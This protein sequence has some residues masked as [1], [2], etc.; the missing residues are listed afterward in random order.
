MQEEFVPGQRWLSEAE[1]DLG[2]GVVEEVGARQVKLNFAASGESRNYAAVNAPLSRVLFVPD[3]RVQDEDGQNLVILEVENIAGLLFYRCVNSAGVESVLPEQSLND[4]LRL[5]RPQ[6]KLLARRIDADIWFTLRYQSWLQSAAQW[7]SPVFG[8][9][10]PRIDLIP[11]QLYIAS[12]VASRAS[13][14]V[15]LA[16]EVGLG[17]TIEAGLVLHRLVL[18]ERVQ[19]VLVILPDAL[20]HQWLVEML[21]RFNMQF[22]VF[23]QDRFDNVDHVN[24]FQAEQRV[25]CSL[26]F[27]TASPQ[28]AQA[29]LDGEWDLLIVDEAHHLAWTEEET[30]LSYQLVEALAEQTASVLLLTATPEQLGRAGHF[31]R[32]RLLDPQRFHDYAAFVAEEEAYGPVA[33]LAASLLDEKNLDGNQRQL[34]DRLLGEEADLA[35][36]QIISRLIDRHGTGRVLFRNT[37]QAI[38]GF[39]KRHLNTSALVLPQAYLPHAADPQPEHAFG[40]GWTAV[41]PRVAWLRDLLGRL[42]PEKVLVICARAE[43]AIAL[44]DHLLERCA[45]HAAMFHERME[46]IARDRSAA[47][48]AD[49]DEGTQVLICSEIGSEGRNFQFAHHLVLFDLPLEADLLEQRIGRL[50]RIGQRDTIELHVPYLEG[51]ASEALMRWYRDGLASFEATCPAASAVFDQLGEQLLST[52][53]EPGQVDQLVAEAARLTAR[54]N[55][56]LE[57]GRDRLLELHSHQPERAAELVDAVQAR[58]GGAS[59]NEYMVAYWDAFGVEHERGPGNSTVLR[60]GA[61]MFNEHMPGLGGGAVTVTFER[62]D[63]LAHED[64]Q[65]LSWEHPMVRGSMEM[66]TSGELGAAAVTVCSHPDHRTGTVF[67]EVL[68]VTECP[69]PRGLEIQRYLPATCLRFLLDIQGEDRS[70]LLAHDQLTGLC[71]SQNRKLADTVIKSQGAR[72]KLLLA[73]AEELAQAQGAELAERALQQMNGE[74]AAEQQRL[75]ALAQVNPNVRDEEIEQ[76]SVRRELI[77]AHLQDTRVRLD[78]VRVIVM[79]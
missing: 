29:V 33:E 37:R 30:G 18:T 71:L 73:H 26:S 40:E 67:L 22:A 76:L 3:D 20:V 48:F 31:G 70:S 53:G 7:R 25:L 35:P 24:P 78:A 5:N 61:H 68:F 21:R 12:E 74:L 28:V 39:P 69:A 66:L 77:A 8:L 60:P 79:R 34:L 62:G 32:L 50:D 64:R 1:P 19:R 45:V 6:D 36:E 75:V 43:T 47:F 42:A 44:R 51:S 54:I 11:H 41:D 55:A 17:K 23:D 59:L 10:G 4:R 65:F 63:A 14:R 46:I 13:P 15:L 2:L 57:Q 56:E 16:D 52:L 72:I 58:V 38:K 9:Q 27:L 49:P